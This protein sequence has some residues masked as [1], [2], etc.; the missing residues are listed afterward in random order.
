MM[1]QDTLPTLSL[2]RSYQH[3]WEKSLREFNSQQ[4]DR[5]QITPLTNRKYLE[6]SSRTS[7]EK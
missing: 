6:V 4:T 1:S 7:T 5:R 3:G 2:N